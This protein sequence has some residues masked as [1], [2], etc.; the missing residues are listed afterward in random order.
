MKK[1]KIVQ[2]KYLK[3]IILEGLKINEGGLKKEGIS[4]EGLREGK[5]K[6]QGEVL[7]SI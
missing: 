4:L 1:V 2:S 3:K 6:V 7:V 5:V